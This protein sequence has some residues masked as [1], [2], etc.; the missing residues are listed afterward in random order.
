MT[1]VV[2]RFIQPR[3]ETFLETTTALE[4]SLDALCKN[5]SNKMLS[6]SRFLFSS[7]VRAW[8]GIELVRFG[9]VTENNRFERILFYP[10]RKSTGLK[11]VQRILIQSDESAVHLER[12]PQKSVAVQGLGALEYV[13]FGNGS[14]SLR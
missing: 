2:M 5:P 6:K 3:Y 12:L 13:L 1:N 14:D 4:N 11:Q 8:A 9:P 7:T 10:D